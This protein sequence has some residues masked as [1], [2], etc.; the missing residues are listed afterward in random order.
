[1][2]LRLTGFASVSGLPASWSIP[3]SSQLLSI[4]GTRNSKD[5]MRGGPMQCHPEE[6]DS[7]TLTALGLGSPGLFQPHTSHMYVQV[8]VRTCP[9]HL[10]LSPSCPPNHHSGKPKFHGER[11]RGGV[12]MRNRLNPFKECNSRDNALRL[13]TDPFQGCQG[14]PTPFIF[15]AG[16][17]GY[18]GS[19]LLLIG[20]ELY[21]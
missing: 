21:L 10:P 2:A 5:K 9:F 17:C 6:R 14:V 18:P 20:P 19:S 11:R 4:S 12:C 8:Y 16:R 15:K 1:M 3:F 7:V 13:L